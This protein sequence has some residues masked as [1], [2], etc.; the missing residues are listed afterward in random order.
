[1]TPRTLADLESHCD[2]VPDHEFVRAPDLR[3][4]HG[5]L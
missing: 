5:V 4:F 2:E 1:M 3:E